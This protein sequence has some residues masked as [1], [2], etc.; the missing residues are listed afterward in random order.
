MKLLSVVGARPQFVKAGPVSR[1]LAA[2][3]IDEVLVH[4]GQHYDANMSGQF[5]EELHLPQPQYHLGIG[6]GSHGAQTG[7]MLELLETVMQKESPQAVMV[8]G[9]TNSTL[10]GALAAAKLNI[11]LIHV[12]AGLR[13]FNRA[14]PEEINRVVADHLS[15]LLLAPT[16]TA[17]AN[18][19]RE[20]FLEYA[21][22]GNGRPPLPRGRFV[23]VGDVMKDALLAATAM[24]RRNGGWHAG[25]KRNCYYL[26]S[27]HRPANVDD[28]ERLW[29]WLDA[30]MQSDLPVLLPLH[31]RT[32]RVAEQSHLLQRV[33]A[34]L[35]ILDPLG[36]VAMITA[37]ADARAV[38]TDSGGLQ[39][40][41]FML[42]V[43]CITLRGETEWLETLEGG[44][45][46]LCPH[47]EY[48]WKCA[49]SIP[50]DEAK[51]S[52]VYGD[53]DAAKKI[54]Q[55]LEHWL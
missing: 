52:A 12:E 9:D 50:T 16:P 43:P 55:C 20:G 3:G 39:K 33:H 28:P 49:N 7:K 17:C 54:V 4:T 25:L 40:E 14:M 35:R 34:P 27:L 26:A 8:Y 41:A 5:F 21:R 18:L 37:A 47:P 1:E 15:T 22:N 36:Y 23:L 19:C 6:S 30:F 46:Q 42:G 48:L 10:A 53:G 45:N 2:A 29:L 11:R 31:P 51:S 13:S 24:A 44:W 38:L 32:R